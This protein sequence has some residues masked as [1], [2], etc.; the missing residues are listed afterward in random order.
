MD[1]LSWQL[2]YEI[3]DL[4]LP[5]DLIISTRPINLS[6][7]V[8]FIDV[9]P[10]HIVNFLNQSMS[11]SQYISLQ[12]EEQE[13][14]RRRRVKKEEEFQ[15]KKEKNFQQKK[16]QKKKK[17]KKK[18]IKFELL[19]WNKDEILQLTLM[20]LND[21]RLTLQHIYPDNIGELILDK[22][23][24][25]PKSTIE[26]IEL[27]LTIPI[28]EFDSYDT[29]IEIFPIIPLIQVSRK[30]I[31]YTILYTLGAIL[32]RLNHDELYILK[33]CALI[34]GIISAKIVIKSYPLKIYNTKQFNQA[35]KNLVYHY[36]LLKIITND[37]RDDIR[38]RS[39][40][41]YL[42][43]KAKRS[44]IDYFNHISSSSSSS[45]GSTGSTVS[46]PLTSAPAYQT[47]TQT[48]MYHRLRKATISMDQQAVTTNDLNDD[49]YY[50]Q[51]HYIF[52]DGFMADVIRSRMLKTTIEKIEGQIVKNNGEILPKLNEDEY[53]SDNNDD[54]NKVYN[55]S[56]LEG[57]LCKSGG[58]IQTWKVRY[59]ILFSD[60]L[61]YFATLDDAKKMQAKGEILLSSKTH[62]EWDNDKGTTEF[63][64]N[65]YPNGSHIIT[66]R[67]YR[68]KA[69]DFNQGQK[70]INMIRNKVI[71]GQAA[72]H[73]RLRSSGAR[74]TLAAKR[75]ISSQQNITTPLME[76]LDSINKDDLGIVHY[77]KVF[78][79]SV[80]EGWML[81][82]GGSVKTWKKIFYYVSR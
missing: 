46:L 65:I 75:A 13:Q 5:I 15:Q 58:K 82:T 38:Q 28:I 19:P 30:F 10:S 52:R 12:E 53:D 80:L 66:D 25:N 33:T 7:T 63:M 49:E 1:E 45:T 54:I 3:Y 8:P 43:Y 74:H 18:F 34:Y 17:K 32:D 29:E 59:S 42:G 35:F 47:Q 68:F 36:K 81:K 64:F 39:H 23:H 62:I 16:N 4:S 50:L 14:R 70:W 9:I 57:W 79:E 51:Q 27:C 24:G 78:E 48:S 2:L 72:H 55:S 26:Y 71:T 6:N 76:G 40:S 41:K 22:S 20:M 31:P 56:L 44:S 61:L 69:E 60:K 77:G 21:K 11:Y 67:I 37:D 73:N